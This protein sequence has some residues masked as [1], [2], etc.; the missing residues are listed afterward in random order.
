MKLA[1]VVLMNE[2]GSEQWAGSLHE[3]CRAN[4]YGRE[5]PRQIRADMTQAHG[6][7]EPTILGGGAAPVFYLSLVA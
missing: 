3:F 4:E 6:R 7:P 1:Q 2:D 5:L